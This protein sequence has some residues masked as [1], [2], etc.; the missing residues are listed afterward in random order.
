MR[1]EIKSSD[2]HLRT[3][4]TEQ[5]FNRG[6]QISFSHM[7]YFKESLISLHWK[8][9]VWYQMWNRWT[10]IYRKANVFKIVTATVITEITL[11]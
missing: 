2:Y 1:S 3:E 4:K 8:R 10:E 7:K 6:K 9:R 11:M 5:Q